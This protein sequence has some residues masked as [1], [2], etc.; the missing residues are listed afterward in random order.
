MP[1]AVGSS[2]PKPKLAAGSTTMAP[3]A[4]AKPT[5]DSS[6]RSNLPVMM[7]SDSAST[8][9]ASAAEEVRMV[10]MLA[11]V[12]KTGLTKPPMTM[13]SDERR[14]QRQ[15]AEA[16]AMAALPIAGREVAA[17]DDAAP[18]SS[19]GVRIPSIEATS[20]LSL[21]PALCSATIAAV[22]HDQHP[23]AGPQVLELAADDQYRLALR[24]MRSTTASSAS[25]D[26]TSTPAV[27]SIRT[28]TE[29]SFASAR[30]IDH[31]L[32]VAAG[33]AARPA[34]PAPR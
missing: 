7:T 8:T 32:L 33:E 28:S 4:G 1:T 20:A 11:W 19:H 3:I 13:S 29:G 16:G 23:V 21:Q 30:P 24:R 18:W 5:V 27:G 10:V 22:P 31:L 25:L 6:D 12:R 2:R 9:S 15:V 14:Q 34:G 26:L 17:G